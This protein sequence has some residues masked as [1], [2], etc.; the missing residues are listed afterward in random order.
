MAKLCAGPWTSGKPRFTLACRPCTWQPE[1]SA[2]GTDASHLKLQE[3]Q[4]LLENR[5]PMPGHKGRLSSCQIAFHLST[6]H[7]A[8][9][10]KRMKD[11]QKVEARTSFS[12]SP[13]MLVH[14]QECAFNCMSI[15]LCSASMS[16]RLHFCSLMQIEKVCFSRT[17][18]TCCQVMQFPVKTLLSLAFDLAGLDERYGCDIL[19]DPSKSFELNHRA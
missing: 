7:A 4:L 3:L 13:M 14:W 19:C 17:A 12:S 15:V 18:V 1:A 10:H 2:Y 16:S 9:D 6:D 11:A 5:M 8:H